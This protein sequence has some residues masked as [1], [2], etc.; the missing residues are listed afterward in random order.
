M[1]RIDRQYTKRI[2]MV[3]ALVAISINLVGGASVAHA[4]EA[5]VSMNKTTTPEPA[6]EGRVGSIEIL[7]YQIRGGTFTL[8][9]D[10]QKA[11]SYALSDALRGTD[12][13]GITSVP[14]KEGALRKG[15]QVLKLD[16]AII[17][18]AGAVTLA[19]PG[20]AIRIQ[21]GSVGMMGAPVPFQ[22][23]AFGILV[24][25]VGSGLFSFR[26]GREKMQESDDPEVEKIA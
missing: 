22:M 25:A 11:T 12:S 9:I 16:V 5:S 24:A 26:K 20:D 6:I 17:D 2:V 23:A 13:E 4:Q 19:T 15:K 18:G 8:K 21:S 3:V 14:M 10:V 7:D 1:Y